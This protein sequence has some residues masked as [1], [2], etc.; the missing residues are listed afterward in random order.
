MRETKKTSLL[1]VIALVASLCFGNLSA[2]A[3]QYYTDVDEN[4]WAYNW[5]SYMHEKGYIHGY[6]DGTYQPGEYITRAEF[7]TILNYITNSTTPAANKF[8]DNNEGDWYYNQINSA[9]YSGYLHGYGDDTVRPN[10]NITREEAATVIVQAYKITTTVDGTFD[11]IDQVSDWALPYVKLM[12]AYEMPQSEDDNNFRPKDLLLRA[13]AA[14]MIYGIEAGISGDELQVAEV[15]LPSGVVAVSGAENTFKLNDSIGTKNTN[16]Q[17]TIVLEEVENTAGAY[18]ITYT[19]DGVETTV[20]AEELK[21]VVFNENEIQSA[22]L[23]FKFTNPGANTKAL[24]KASV[25]DSDKLVSTPVTYEFTFGAAATEKPS[26]SSGGGLSGG[27]SSSSKLDE[28]RDRVVEALQQMKADDYSVINDGSKYLNNP[29]EIVL[30]ND[31]MDVADITSPQASKAADGKT[32][33]A[34]YIDDAKYTQ[35]KGVYEDVV[36][37]VIANSPTFRDL[38]ASTIAT[39]TKKDYVL[40]FRA[41]VAVI[42]AA[43]DSAV[44]IYNNDAYGTPDDKFNAFILATPNTVLDTIETELTAAGA[45]DELKAEITEQAVNY[46]STIFTTNRHNQTIK[47]Q[48]TALEGDLTIE[49]LAGILNDYLLMD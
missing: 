49:V 24:I 8:I 11:D 31:G 21:A 5:V 30:A 35:L 16:G 23:T 10:G 34:N 4:H 15:V 46:C 36:K 2:F 43:A 14:A 37:Y 17:L 26:G 40:Y 25:F 41:M 18:T 32:E 29:I 27:S 45:G 19:K 38:D 48:L 42:D 22:N 20:T 28:D 39:E 1:V 6:P 7:V 13:E 33:L 44:A 3:A 12:K 9:V 47:D